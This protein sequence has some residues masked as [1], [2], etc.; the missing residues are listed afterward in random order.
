RNAPSRSLAVRQGED[1]DRDERTG[2][3][4]LVF[5]SDSP[6]DSVGSKGKQ[7]PQ[8]PALRSL[9]AP[10][11]T[12]DAQG[13]EGPAEGRSLAVTAEPP[14]GQ[15]GASLPADQVFVGAEVKAS[16][17]DERSPSRESPRAVPLAFSDLPADWARIAPLQ[18][19]GAPIQGTRQEPA[20]A[21]QIPLA[22]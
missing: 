7:G 8:R 20:P 17:A 10:A 4:V 1:D 21:L 22:A 16:L 9:V 3:I 13:S 5:Q 11:A 6:S 15:D 18:L 19:A 2:R 14:S 12:E